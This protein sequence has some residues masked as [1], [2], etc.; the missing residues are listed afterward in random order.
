MAESSVSE[1]SPVH[2]PLLHC[3]LNHAWLLWLLAFG[4]GKGRDKQSPGW[5]VPQLNKSLF[6]AELW[7]SLFHCLCGTSAHWPK[8]PR[9]CSLVNVCPCS[10]SFISVTLIS[11]P[12][13]LM[14]INGCKIRLGFNLNVINQKWQ[15]AN[16]HFVLS[17][18]WAWNFLLD[19]LNFKST[20]TII[21][22]SVNKYVYKIPHKPYLLLLEAYKGLTPMEKAEIKQSVFLKLANIQKGGELPSSEQV[23]AFRK[24]CSR[25]VPC[26]TGNLKGLK[27][28]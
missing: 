16:W 20:C 21:Q 7:Y 23:K 1:K 5:A 6:S 17:K 4:E 8:P 2:S 28:A 25:E 26:D 18:G 11:Y 22:V 12:E 14:H 19:M 3:R 13:L 15:T 27:K 9:I 24:Q 10:Q